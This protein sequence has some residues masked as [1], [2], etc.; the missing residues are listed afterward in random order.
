MSGFVAHFIISFVILFDTLYGSSLSDSITVS[1]EALMSYE[2][3]S[4]EDIF[5]LPGTNFLNSKGQYI[6]IFPKSSYGVCKPGQFKKGK[7]LGS[8]GGGTVFQANYSPGRYKTFDVA[9]KYFPRVTTGDAAALI[10]NEEVIL[11]KMKHASIPKLIC[12]FLTKCGEVGVVMQRIKGRSVAKLIQ[13]TNNFD[14]LAL[15]KHVTR[16]MI[17]VLTF[18]HEN[19]IIHRDVKAENVMLDSAANVFLIDYNLAVHAPNKVVTGIEGTLS[20]MAPEM[21]QGLPYDDG[22][23]WY[24]LG[25]IVYFME[26]G[27]RPFEGQSTMRAMHDKVKNGPPKIDD[28]L[29]ND[30]V[31]NLCHPI[32]D[33]RWSYANGRIDDIENHLY[34]KVFKTK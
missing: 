11:K 3:Q 12:T 33:E 15:R 27:E 6:P 2:T 24:G 8:G 1:G 16:E 22:I 28:P 17:K 5:A 31:Q 30:L 19:S 26:M 25:V 20:S 18:L 21:I 23:D 9:I 10:R 14:Q 34:H 29:A 13:T 32:P 4:M 7:K